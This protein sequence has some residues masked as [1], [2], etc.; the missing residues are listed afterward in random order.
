MMTDMSV[1]LLDRSTVQVNLRR[2]G[3]VIMDYNVN[4]LENVC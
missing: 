2:I 1:W 3:R 4:L